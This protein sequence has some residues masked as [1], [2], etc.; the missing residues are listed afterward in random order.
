M[1]NLWT[2]HVKLSCELFK[3]RIIVIAFT[4]LRR[5]VKVWCPV[6]HLSYPWAWV[7]HMCRLKRKAQDCGVMSCDAHFR[8]PNMNHFSDN[9]LKLTD[10]RLSTIKE[11]KKEITV[12][13]L[14]VVF[15]HAVPWAG[16]LV[17]IFSLGR[18]CRRRG[19]LKRLCALH[20]C[21]AVVQ[22]SHTIYSRFPCQLV[23]LHFQH[24]ENEGGREARGWRCS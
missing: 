22:R 5:S 1:N 8:W 3:I 24:P 19:E 13:Y 20:D 2:Y 6:N 17:L 9:H 14:H 12:V 11:T 7:A 16:L 10:K 23:V 4:E 21:M 15:W 18:R